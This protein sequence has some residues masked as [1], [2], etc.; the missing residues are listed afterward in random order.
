M[1][2]T[3]L[4]HF[5]NLMDHINKLEDSKDYS[6]TTC[7]FRGFF[8]IFLFILCS[9]LWRHF[10]SFPTSTGRTAPHL[11]LHLVI[12]ISYLQEK[13]YNISQLLISSKPKGY[14]LFHPFYFIFSFE[15]IR[16][17]VVRQFLVQWYKPL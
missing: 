1:K 16:L 8:S 7:K 14:N 6:Q 13:G 9:F 4:T 10:L 12:R 15:P 17:C 11:F 5:S 2:V 3:F